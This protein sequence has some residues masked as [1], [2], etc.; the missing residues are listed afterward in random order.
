MA[1]LLRFESL[2]VLLVGGAV[3][4]RLLH[5]GNKARCVDVVLLFLSVYMPATN[6]MPYRDASIDEVLA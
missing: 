6:R 3:V 4:G 2:E 5:Y 1:L